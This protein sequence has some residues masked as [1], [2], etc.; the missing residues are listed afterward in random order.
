MTIQNSKVA[1]IFE[2]LDKFRTYCQI[3]GKVFNEA[4]LY[5]QRNPVWQAYEKYLKYKQKLAQKR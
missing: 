5:N 3:E 2:D 1:Q 4:A